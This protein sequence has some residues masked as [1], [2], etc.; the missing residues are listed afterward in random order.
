MI[1]HEPAQRA[2]RM[3][4]AFW[5][6]CRACGEAIH[7][8]GTHDAPCPCGTWHPQGDLQVLA[9]VPGHGRAWIHQRC[10]DRP[11]TDPEATA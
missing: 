9:E 3:H 4:A 8:P 2:G 5:S 11:T 7:G 1:S 6:V 10:A